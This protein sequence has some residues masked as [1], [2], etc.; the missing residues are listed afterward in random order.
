MGVCGVLLKW[1]SAC[2][3]MLFVKVRYYGSLCCDVANKTAN[4]W[5]CETGTNYNVSSPQSKICHLKKRKMFLQ[6]L[7]NG[8]TAN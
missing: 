2:R 8:E 5:L 7:W 4:N 1:G 3:E 6:L